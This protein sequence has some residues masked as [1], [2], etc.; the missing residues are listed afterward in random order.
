MLL[1]RRLKILILVLKIIVTV[2]VG[3]GFAGFSALWVLLSQGGMIAFLLV[4]L[5][6]VVMLSLNL[7]LCFKACP[8]SR[9]RMVGFF[10]AGVLLLVGAVALNCYLMSGPSTPTYFRSSME[11]ATRFIVWYLLLPIL[12]HS[13]I[14]WGLCV[15]QNATKLD[16]VQPSHTQLN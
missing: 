7:V 16:E 13:G 3:L 12:V 9:K 5:F 15:T 6:H 2:V 11:S 14:T 1:N 4:A 8:L 10:L